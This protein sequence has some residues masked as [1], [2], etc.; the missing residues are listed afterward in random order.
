[1]L[2]N[3]RRIM[4]K[5]VALLS[6]RPHSTSAGSRDG[7]DSEVGAVNAVNGGAAEADKDKPSKGLKDEDTFPRL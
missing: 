7:E 4:S 3:S 2:S 5:Y 1:M 6:G